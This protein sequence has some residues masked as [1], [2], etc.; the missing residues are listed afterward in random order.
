MKRPIEP[1]GISERPE[2]EAEYQAAKAEFVAA[3][4]RLAA[5]RP[6][7]VPIWEARKQAA[8]RDRLEL[9]AAVADAWLAGA[10]TA[11]VCELMGVKHSNPYSVSARVDRLVHAMLEHHEVYTPE[12]RAEMFTKAESAIWRRHVELALARFRAGYK[13]VGRI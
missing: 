13:P 11:D 3:Q 5:I 4:A 1:S 7:M 9:L 2:I 10:A 12:Y 6:A 8:E